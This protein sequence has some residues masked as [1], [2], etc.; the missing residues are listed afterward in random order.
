MHRSFLLAILGAMAILTG[1]APTP[2]KLDVCPGKLNLLDSL[3]VMQNRGS[4]ITGFLAKG[5]CSMQFHVDAKPH[6]ENL[7]I[8]IA[9]NPPAEFYLRG[10]ISIVPKAVVVVS[11]AE[12]FW[13]ALRPKEISTYWWG[14]WDRQESYHDL[15]LS[16]RVMLEVLGISMIDANDNWSLS[17]QG[18][19]DVLT[20]TDAQAKTIR[21]MYV[22]SC[23]Y[24][25][26]II[27][28]FDEDE[29]VA[30]VA[31][32][33]KYKRVVEGFS[34]PTKIQL[35]RPGPGKKKDWVKM[36]LTSVDP[37]KFDK[38]QREIFQRR[39]P[40]GFEHIYVIIDGEAVELR[41]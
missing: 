15:A 23:D 27:E 1:C 25:V 37:K 2:T 28:Y 14:K 21:K 13:L 24:T 5:R 11:N 36:T 16:P 31:E 9:V 3:S 17:N 41:E 8:T 7:R 39:T 6:K 4:N 29:N 35:S 34:I 19:Y 20:K 26:R 30:L 18:P 10:D 40:R 22:Y 33:D 32:L 38:K 12:E